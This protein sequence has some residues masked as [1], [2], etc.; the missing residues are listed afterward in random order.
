MYAG[1]W[2]KPEATLGE[3]AQYWHHTGDLGR[4]DDDGYLYFVDRK[5]QSMRRR[6]ENVSSIELEAAIRKHPAVDEVAVHAVP[7]DLSE[8]EIKAVIIARGGEAPDLGEL[9]EYFVGSLP[10]FAVP[11]YVEFRRE[12]PV[13]AMGRVMKHLLKAEGITPETIDLTASGFVIKKSQRR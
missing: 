12:L 4:L 1:Y 7:S 11:R 2:R 9:F 5:Q 8:D 3:M 6:G 13:N 10:Y